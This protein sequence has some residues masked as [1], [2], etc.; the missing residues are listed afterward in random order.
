MRE[1]FFGEQIVSV[2][3]G[4]QLSLVSNSCK[5]NLIR[6]IDRVSVLLHIINSRNAVG[7]FMTSLALNITIAVEQ[8]PGF[9]LVLDEK[10]RFHDFDLRAY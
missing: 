3:N 5:A 1:A 4:K 6:F 9:Y 8:K 10:Q 2:M 7:N